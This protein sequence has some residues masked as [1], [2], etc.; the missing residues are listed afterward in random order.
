MVIRA[1]LKSSYP[2]E[3]WCSPGTYIWTIPGLAIDTELSS[4]LL[5]E[6]NLQSDQFTSWSKWN[7]LTI[8]HN[9]TLAMHFFS[10]YQTSYN[11]TIR[12]VWRHIVLTFFDILL[13]SGYKIWFKCWSP[14]KKIRE[15]LWCFI[16]IMTYIRY[17]P[18]IAILHLNCQHTCRKHLKKYRILTLLAIYI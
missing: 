9:K 4:E 7:C 17:W 14:M 13:N 10:K 15:S 2:P 5:C 16:T 8:N 18:T 3:S 12:L 1:V 6:L 11:S